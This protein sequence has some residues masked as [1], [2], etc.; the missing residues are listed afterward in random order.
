MEL[1]SEHSKPMIRRS[2]TS[3]NI[4][5]IRHEANLEPPNPQSL[6][7]LKIPE[8]FTKLG[9]E[10]FLKFDGWHNDERIQAFRL[11]YMSFL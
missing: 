4:R 2:L 9:E 5:N 8:E 10:V 1:V 6:K 3:R 7:D 11:K